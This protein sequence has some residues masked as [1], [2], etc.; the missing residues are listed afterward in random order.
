MAEAVRT[1]CPYC[2]VGCGVLVQR[3][4]DGLS[5]SGDPDHPANA[6]RLCVK[7]TALGETVG[8]DGRLLHPMIDGRQT[9]WESALDRLADEFSKAISVHGP[10]S[11]AFYVS[12]QLLTEDYY[13]ANKLMKGFIGS[14]N[15]DTN[16]RLCM[17]S[18]VAGHQRAFGADTVPGCYEDL[19]LADLVVLVGSNAAWCHPVL[20]QRVQAARAARPGM[21]LVVIDP[22][23]T[24]TADS[25]D[26]HLALR[27]GSDVALFNG[28]L[29]HL[30]ESGRTD[31]TFVAAHCQGAED[32]LDAAKAEPSDA[33]TICDVDPVD[34][35]CFYDWFATTEKV[36]TVFSQG[37]NQSS[38]GTD[39]VNAIINCHLL[40]GRIG[41]PGMGPLSFTGQPNAMG[42]REV[43]GLANQLAAHMGFDEPSRDRIGRFWQAPAVSRQSGLKAVDLFQAIDQGRIKAL[44]IV[45]TNPAVSLPESALV[46]RALDR[47]AFVAVSDCVAV[48]DTSLRAH[49]LLPALTWA[50]KDGT[51]TNS[52]RCISRQRPV[53][54]PPGEAK[55]DWWIICR[56]AERMG[57]GHAFGYA[58]PAEIFAEHARLSTFE[59]DGTRDFDIGGL[60][61]VDYDRMEPSQWPVREAGK[62]TS[63]VFAK[64]G[65]YHA[66]GKARLIAL[67]H[68]PPASILSDDWPLA[69]NTGRT[70]DQ[71]HTMTRTGKAPRLAAHTPEP[72]LA[73]HPKDAARLDLDEGAMAQVESANGQAVLRVSIDHTQREGEVFAPMHW[74][75]QFAGQATV[76]H[77]LPPI[78]DP[79]SGQPELKYAAVR[80]VPILLAWEAVLLTRR[81]VSTWTP[82]VHWSRS[83]GN[84][85]DIYRL[86][87]IERVEDWAG[88]ARQRLGEG[89]WLDYQ[90]RRIGLY[91]AALIHDSRLDALLFVAAPGHRPAAEDLAHLFAGPTPEPQYRTELLAGGSVIGRCDGPIVC[92]C[93]HVGRQVILEAI[94]GQG[95]SSVEAIGQALRAGTNC[96][97]CIPELRGL[98][99]SSKAS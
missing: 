1:T 56:L 92:A 16:S 36:V 81:P 44:W 27:P 26:L 35:A 68:R 41:R 49:L 33:A 86:A 79:L 74:N 78:T 83:A 25:A 87:G 30:A 18:S 93:H 6:G 55:P 61:D 62:S 45:A 57:F 54:D 13:V 47:C 69:L 71:W 77:L 14:S 9:D 5:V 2:G 63:R 53:L 75:D 8:L 97:S 89:I 99:K 29:R 80:I 22:R 88:W 48:T 50:E 12:G 34:L 84:G 59:N 82:D 37:V 7:G 24:A 72:W 60:A 10:D 91:R 76:G 17:S 46:R 95:L 42:G 94:A 65:F 70:R 38:A 23:R 58:G 21:R 11:V 96:G 32:A 3:T 28:L 39:K 85:H 98:L 90:D 73:I 51:V 67:H 20:F 52:E 43:G 4:T 66:D 64:G 31:R 15:I 19:E 40:T